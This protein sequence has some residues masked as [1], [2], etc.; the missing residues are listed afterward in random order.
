MKV[1]S[2]FHKEKAAFKS[3]TVSSSHSNILRKDIKF[4][5]IPVC[6][7]ESSLLQ[8]LKYLW[9]QH[10]HSGRSPVKKHLNQ[11]PSRFNLFQNK[12]KVW[13]WHWR[14]KTNKQNPSELVFSTDILIEM[15]SVNYQIQSGTSAKS[16]AK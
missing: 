9:I 14:M 11:R 13:S 16:L 15:S 8:L 3:G 6:T 12:I 2:S 1:I 4:W 10:P 5:N 7:V